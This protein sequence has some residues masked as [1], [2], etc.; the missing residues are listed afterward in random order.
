MNSK[1]LN[2]HKCL[3]LSRAILS[4]GFFIS[5]YL[6]LRRTLVQMINKAANHPGL[7]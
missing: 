6:F 3:Q 4:P 1:Y 5:I 7:Q 2:E